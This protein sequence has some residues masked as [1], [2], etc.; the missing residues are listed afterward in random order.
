[1]KAIRLFLLA[2]TISFLA[3]GCL[4]VE[5]V[6]TVKPDGSGTVTETLIVT[7]QTI[8]SLKEM[9][10]SL[11]SGG[12]EAKPG[13]AP[14]SP[15]IMDEAKLREAAAR[16]GE[17]VTFLSARK[18][19][20]AKGEG[21]TAMYAFTDVSKLKLN[22]NPSDKMPVAGPGVKGSEER[23]DLQFEFTKGSPATLIVRSP[24]A[25]PS[26]KEAKKPDSGKDDAMA[27]QMMQQILKDMRVA[28]SIKVD[29]TITETDAEHRDATRVTLMDM[30]F[31]KLL[32][33]PEKFKALNKANPDS[34]EETKRMM[35][36]IPGVKVETKPAVKI[37][38]K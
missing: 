3:S 5:K 17:G 32:A 35:N 7:K 25:K 20:T 37:Q 30:D 4:D 23:E 27:A 34:F 8:E 26:G 24:E 18:I 12:A 19:T 14:K 13:A 9:A 36:G 6:V 22:Q 11:G 31:N 38:F 21:Y 16:M 1:V 15:E 33:N 28:V 10:G 29:G 2:L